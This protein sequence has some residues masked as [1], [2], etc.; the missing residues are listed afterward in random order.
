MQTALSVFL[1][2]HGTTS[3]KFMET[4]VREGSKP[5]RTY[6]NKSQCLVITGINAARSTLLK[7]F[8]LLI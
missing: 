4:F 8:K 6:R 2:W 1:Y 5:E 7:C 3:F